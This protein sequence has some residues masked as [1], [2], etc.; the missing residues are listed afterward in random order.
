MRQRGYREPP[1]LAEGGTRE[2][3][4]AAQKESTRRQEER[5]EGLVTSG[6]QQLWQLLPT[7]RLTPYLRPFAAPAGSPARIRTALVVS[8]DKPLWAYTRDDHD[9]AVAARIRNRGGEPLRIVEPHLVGVWDEMHL[10]P[11]VWGVDGRS[12]LELSVRDVRRHLIRCSH[13]TM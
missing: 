6:R 7:S 2:G 4:L 13:V 9:A 5:L 3:A 8:K 12:L 1:E 11:V 10:D